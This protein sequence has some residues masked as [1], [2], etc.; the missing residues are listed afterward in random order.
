MYTVKL[1]SNVKVDLY[2]ATGIP[3]GVKIKVVNITPNDISLYSSV[4]E[5]VKSDATLPLLF[6]RG[7]AF[8]DSN[9][10]GAWAM[11]PGAG[12]IHVEVLT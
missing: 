7:S 5:P 9:D 3:V 6:G 2:D 8:N 10:V 1:P 4:G 11:C 12:A